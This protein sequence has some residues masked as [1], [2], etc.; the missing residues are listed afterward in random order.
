MFRKISLLLLCCIASL[1]I[2]AQNTRLV[3]GVVFSDQEIPLK[4][5]TITLIG[6]PGSTQT[7]EN[8]LFEFSVSPYAKQVEATCEGYLPQKAEI[9][10]TY[11]IFK[12]KVDKKYAKQKAKEEEEARLAAQREAEAKAKAEEE[13]RIAAQ[14]A[15]EQARIAAQREAEAKAK[16]EEQARIAAQ[17]EAEAKAKAE[18]QARL[19]AEKKARQEAEAK[20]KAEEQ[21]RLAA[22]KAERDSLAKIAAEK[23][24]IEYA[25]QQSGFASMIDVSYRLPLNV[26]SDN[27]GASYTAGYRISNTLYVGAGAGINYFFKSQPSQV[28]ID[29]PCGVALNPST[30]TIPVFA[31][32]RANFTN[33]QFSPFFALAAGYELGSKQKLNLDLYSVEYTTGGFFANPQIGINY[34]TSLK[35]SL[36]LAVGFQAYS[37]PYCTEHTGYNATIKQELAY[38]VDIHLGLTF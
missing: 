20:A 32:F 7:D 8:G 2:V 34:R 10:G 22:E 11:L 16:A 9:D 19:A 1:T 37:M 21:A 29:T 26:A 38:G 33:A 4:G 6:M 5:A 24:R 36:Y 31:Y 13:A 18:E 12:L 35:T 30:I 3:K 23:R 25:K 28:S 27:I 14:K 15:E 17:R